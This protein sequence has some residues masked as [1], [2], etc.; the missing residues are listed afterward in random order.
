MELGHREDQSAPTESKPQRTYEV[1]TEMS[2][3]PHNNLFAEP[4]RSSLPYSVAR[5]TG[6]TGY[7]G[8]MIDEQRLVGMKDNSSGSLAASD[9]DVFTL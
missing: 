9:I 2:E 5:L 6:V 1:R 4:V 3:I 8:F 7:T